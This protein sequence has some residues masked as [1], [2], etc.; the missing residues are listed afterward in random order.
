MYD[1]G[2]I[3]TH[4]ENEMYRKKQG[5]AKVSCHFRIIRCLCLTPKTKQHQNI[6]NQKYPL[7]QTNFSHA[8]IVVE[9]S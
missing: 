8:F 7:T 5:D 4:E 1:K 9:F 6:Q 3:C 2:W